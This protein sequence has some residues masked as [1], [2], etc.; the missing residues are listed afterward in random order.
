MAVLM[1]T[2][3]SRA[4]SVT[5]PLGGG[6]VD[7]AAPGDGVRGGRGALHQDHHRGETL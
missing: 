5:S 6:D 7:A 1:M 3:S 2:A 4:S